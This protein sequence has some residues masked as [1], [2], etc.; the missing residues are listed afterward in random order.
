MAENDR[1][2]K[3]YLVNRNTTV[4]KQLRAAGLYPE[5][6]APGFNQQGGKIGPGFKLTMSA[7]RGTIYH[8]TNGMDPRVYATGAV[9][10][11]AATYADGPLPLAATV[12]VKA[13][14]LS[15]R[16]WSAMNEALFSVGQ[17]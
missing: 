11:N 7:R 2:V 14:A 3:S 17:E 8:T 4:L 5:L 13:R 10:S 9:S 16:T 1:I 12:T 6:D 15:G